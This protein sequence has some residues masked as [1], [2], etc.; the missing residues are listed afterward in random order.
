M[1]RGGARFNSNG[2]C[3]TGRKTIPEA[4]RRV[5]VGIRLRRDLWERLRVPGVNMS[6]G[7]EQALD[8]KF[9][10]EDLPADRQGHLMDMVR[11]DGYVEPWNLKHHFR[12]VCS[13]MARKAD[14]IR[15][16]RKLTP[17]EESIL[18]LFKCEGE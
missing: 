7:I 11:D 5:P 1:V 10:F 3:V 15:A 6:R 16:E 8:L 2:K 9:A 18:A 12:E 4:Q 14:S 17:G 13:H